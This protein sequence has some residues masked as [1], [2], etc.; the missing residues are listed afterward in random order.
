MSS[1]IGVRLV[2]H[3]QKRLLRN[4]VAVLGMVSIAS[5]IAAILQVDLSANGLETHFGASE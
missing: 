3:E 1:R 5:F 2:E 4:A